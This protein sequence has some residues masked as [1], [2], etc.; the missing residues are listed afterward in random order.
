M[1]LSQKCCFDTPKNTYQNDPHL[2]LRLMWAGKAERTSFKVPAVSLHAHE[3]IDAKTIVQAVRTHN[4]S[5][6]LTAWG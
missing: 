3:R 5:G 4:G 6:E 1:V 2:D